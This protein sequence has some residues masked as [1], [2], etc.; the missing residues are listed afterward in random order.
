MLQ[1]MVAEITVAHAQADALRLAF[2][3]FSGIVLD[4][5]LPEGATLPIL[6][7]LRA[8]GTYTPTLVLAEPS[9][10]TTWSAAQRH[11]AYLLPKPCRLENLSAFVF[12][13]TRFRGVAHAQLE[14]QIRALGHLHKW[15]AR[16]QEIVR[17]AASGIARQELMAALRV[18]E[19]TVKTTVR[20]LLR[21]CRRSTLSEIVSEV[22]R[23]VFLDK[24][25]KRQELPMCSA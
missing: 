12:W 20:R 18:E 3:P 6:A 21:K 14:A 19:S 7:K 1:P 16:E 10:L 17:L 25:A 9:D 24:D 5:G 15:T 8:Q 2:S 23:A 13:T 11:G 22:H 4:S